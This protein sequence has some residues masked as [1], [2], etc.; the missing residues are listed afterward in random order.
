VRPLFTSQIHTRMP[1]S[2]LCDG[3]S[4]LRKKRESG[5]RLSWG[6]K[7]IGLEKVVGPVVCLHYIAAISS[8]ALVMTDGIGYRLRDRSGVV[9]AILALIL[10]VS[11]PLLLL[12]SRAATISAV[13]FGMVVQ[14]KLVAAMQIRRV[15]AHSDLVVFQIADARAASVACF[16]CRVAVGVGVAAQ[17][18]ADAEDVAEDVLKK[19][20][21]GWDCG[22]DEACVELS[23]DPDCDSCSVICMFGEYLWVG[24]IHSCMYLQVGLVVDPNRGSSVHL[25]MAQTVASKPIVNTPRRAHLL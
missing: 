14:L 15:T 1:S 21:E 16:W 6:T 22:G 24:H 13:P 8:C 17:L 11:L 19:G 18:G 25:A 12:E 3:I 5:N 2:D 20:F 7:S 4:F 23:A 10:T 9:S